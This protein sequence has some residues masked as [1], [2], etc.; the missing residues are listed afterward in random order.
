MSVS[1]KVELCT[2][3]EVESNDSIWQPPPVSICHNDLGN[4]IETIHDY[5]Y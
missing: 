4:S 2:E 1:I 5:G 3:D